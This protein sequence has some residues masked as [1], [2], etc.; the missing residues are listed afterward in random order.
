MACHGDIQN[1]LREICEMKKQAGAQ[2]GALFLLQHHFYI[3][4]NNK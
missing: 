3:T 1:L 4:K 2:N